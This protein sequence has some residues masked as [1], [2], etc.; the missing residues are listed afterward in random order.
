MYPGGCSII[1][2]LGLPKSC[3][4]KSGKNGTKWRHFRKHLRKSLAHLQSTEDQMVKVCVKICEPELKGGSKV[5]IDEPH[6]N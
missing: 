4:S 3:Q 6:N 1:P 2:P 5:G